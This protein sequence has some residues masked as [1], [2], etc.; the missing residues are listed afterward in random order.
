MCLVDNRWLLKIADYG[1]Y[2]LRQGNEEKEHPTRMLYKAPELLRLASH[3]RPKYGSR[4]GDIYSF[5]I[6]LYE[7]IYRT[8]PYISD[9]LTTEGISFSFLI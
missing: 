3:D 9:H 2:P 4:K 8:M 7:I 5:G 6:I 1:L